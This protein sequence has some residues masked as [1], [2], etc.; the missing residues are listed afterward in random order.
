LPYLSHIALVATEVIIALD[1]EPV[2]SAFE[3]NLAVQAALLHDVIE[4]TP[5]TP[6]QVAAAFGEPVRDAVLALTKDDC[7]PT[8]QAQMAD[9]LLRIRHQPT[10]VWLVKMADRITNLM[11][12]PYY[13]TDEKIAAYQ[14]EARQI[15]DALGDAS[16]Y[17]AARLDER[18]MAYGP[19]LRPQAASR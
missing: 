8:K 14:D 5:T 15:R 17:L 10:A 1:A 11:P 13:W 18:I 12:P 16:P 6:E 4:D 3:Q 2:W 7:L 9:S 19:H